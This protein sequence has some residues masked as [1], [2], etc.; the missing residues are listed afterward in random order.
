MLFNSLTFLIFLPC[1]W[2]LYRKFDLRRQNLLLLFASYLFY[3][4]WD[5][6]FLS[7]LWIS[8]VIDYLC[9]LG[10]KHRPAGK[11]LF[12]YAS[13]VSNLGILG[14]FKYYDFFVHS[15]ARALS[16]LGFIPHLTVLGIILPVGISFS[17]QTT[18]YTIDAGILRSTEPVNSARSL[19]PA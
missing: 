16:A 6:R 13:L 4:W 3:G 8:T 18:A 14:F 7:L 17:F 9:G 12:L 5:W 2:L 19:P 15:A 10:M 11:R 1:V